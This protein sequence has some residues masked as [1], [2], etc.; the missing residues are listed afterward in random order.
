MDQYFRRFAGTR[1]LPPSCK[2]DSNAFK[3]V[4]NL[5][6]YVSQV[7]LIFYHT[8]TTY[9]KEGKMNKHVWRNNET[10]NDD[11]SHRINVRSNNDDG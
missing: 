9:S 8:N 3:R 5:G 7:S 2:T 10:L 11:S 1:C 4:K 6:A